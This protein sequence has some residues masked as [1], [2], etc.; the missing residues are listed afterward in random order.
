[1]TKEQSH[2]R[3]EWRGTKGQIGR[4]AEHLHAQLSGAAV[5]ARPGRL[6]G[7]AT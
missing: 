4:H 1:M 3:D 7:L 5:T 6:I 2:A